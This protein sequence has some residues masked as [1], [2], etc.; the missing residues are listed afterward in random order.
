MRDCLHSQNAYKARALA[1]FGGCMAAKI[2]PA[3]WLSAAL[4]RLQ[5]EITRSQTTEVPL[6][7]LDAYITYAVDSGDAKGLGALFDKATVLRN[8]SGKTIIDSARLQKW[9]A[10]LQ[11]RISSDVAMTDDRRNQMRSIQA[12]LQ[13]YL[14]PI[15]AAQ[16]THM[17]KIPAHD[18]ASKPYMKRIPA[19]TSELPFDVLLEHAAQR[20]VCE[21]FE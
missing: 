6:K 15:P 7:D 12:I 2:N 3:I 1:R 8:M 10:V 19:A 17:Q 11:M 4:A 9:L 18:D 20:R 5:E 13:N 14:A 21:A 16:S